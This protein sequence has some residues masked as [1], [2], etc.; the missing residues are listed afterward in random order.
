MK[1]KKLILCVVCM[2]LFCAMVPIKPKASI[3][4]KVSAEAA[5]LMDQ[6]TKKVLYDKNIN[7]RMKI[8][9]ITKIMTAILALEIGDLTKLVTISNDAVGVEGSSI[10]L[11]QG[12]QVK[13][14]DLIYGL[15][16]RSGNDA[17]VAI[18][19]YIAGSEEEF[20]KL[21]NRKASSLGMKNT[22]FTNPHGLDNP[23]HY[24][25]AY[26]MALLTQYAMQNAEFRKIFKTKEHPIPP[27]LVLDTSTWRNKNKLLFDYPYSTGGKTGFTRASGRTL[28][29]TASKDGIDLIV[30]TL[31]DP[32]DWQ[33][34][35][36]LFNLG[37]KEEG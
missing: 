28:V 30:V 22:N 13:L 5:I 3:D 27:E 25:T 26:D 19:D 37:F 11:K 32:D 31:N 6:N 8:A 9:S 4:A 23:N 34:H 21:M 14:E 12:D 15:M 33:D 2:I 35:M 29:S 10:N 17:A 16:L 20:V 7:K 18:A 1:Y 36:N 24:S